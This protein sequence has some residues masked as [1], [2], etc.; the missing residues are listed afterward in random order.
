MRLAKSFLMLGAVLIFGS[1]AKAD[2]IRVTAT[3]IVFQPQNAAPS[4][5]FT[6]SSTFLF[7][8]GT[9]QL[10]PGTM[11]THVTDTLPGTPFLDWVPKPNFHGPNFTYFDPSLDGVVLVFGEQFPAI[12]SYPVNSSQL[13]CVSDDCV[14]HFGGTRD[15]LFGQSGELSISA[16]SEP[17]PGGG[18]LLACGV[19]GVALFV[20]KAKF[21]PHRLN[22]IH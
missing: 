4:Q 9:S 14:Q 2:E 7:D 15:V 10:V 1:T 19:L 12:G 13:F 3:N 8:L 17:E 5:Q 22:H 20:T 11:S 18:L 16:V 6:F 21:S